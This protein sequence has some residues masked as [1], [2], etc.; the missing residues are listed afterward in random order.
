MAVNVFGGGAITPAQVGFRQLELE[1]DTTL[2]WPSSYLDT[3]NVLPYYLLVTGVEEEDLNLT[4]PAAN[5]VGVGMNF[6]INNIGTEDFTLRTNGGDELG[7]IAAGTCYFYIISDN[8]TVDGTWVPLT[9]G[10]GTSSADANALA[11]K[12]LKAISTTLNTNIPTVSGITTDQTIVIADRAKLFIWQG[13]VGVFTLPDIVDAPNGFY[14]SINNQGTGDITVEG[15]ANINNSSDALSV[16]LGQSVT[17]VSDGT[18]WWDLGYNPLTFFQ[19]SRIDI[20]VSGNTNYPLSTTEAFNN[21]IEFSGAVTGDIIVLFP[22]AVDEW[23]LFNDTTGAGSVS[24]RLDSGGTTY[25]LPKG[26]RMQFYSDGNSMRDAQTSIKVGPG[27]TAG[28]PFTMGSGSIAAWTGL[29]LLQYTT[30]HVNT[31]LGPYTN[32]YDTWQTV[33]TRTINTAHSNSNVLIV[34]QLTISAATAGGDYG[35]VRMTRN[36]TPINV[37]GDVSSGW[38]SKEVEYT[39]RKSVV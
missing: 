14:I 8:S 27:V 17:L 20:D 21:I 6:I 11:G 31:T 25:L 35:F 7:T 12:G 4:L 1:E 32:V 15:D 5:Q 9:F 38:S 26:A 22:S 30:Q 2:F 33:L 13:G 37:Q 39:D 34:A 24:V 3:S 28:R 18:A 19:A 29:S 36:T 10:T 16:T 23:T